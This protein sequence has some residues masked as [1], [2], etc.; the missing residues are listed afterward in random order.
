LEF[1][2]SVGFIHKESKRVWKEAIPVLES[3]KNLNVVSQPSKAKRHQTR[4]LLAGSIA[5]D[6]ELGWTHEIPVERWRQGET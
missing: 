3:H 1:S 2:A 4:Q 6:P 5:C